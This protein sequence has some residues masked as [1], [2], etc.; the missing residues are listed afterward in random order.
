ME[1]VSRFFDGQDSP[2]ARFPD[3]VEFRAGILAKRAYNRIPFRILS[4]I[5]WR[6]ELASRSAKTEATARP[7]QLWVEHVMPVAWEENWP[8]HSEVRE[9]VGYEDPHYREL[10]WKREEAIH[11]LGNL[12]I[13]TDR[14]NRSLTNLAFKDKKSKF[15]EHSNLTLN[16]RIAVREDWD[17]SAIRERGET[18]ATL[19][20]TI[21]P[22]PIAFIQG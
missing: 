8:L 19:A 22:M 17:E 5:L 18:L 13:V 11:T 14:L 21:W 16:R 1:T 2:T 6:L 9:S 4:D 10:H 15:I 7:S 3:D 12:T 20:C